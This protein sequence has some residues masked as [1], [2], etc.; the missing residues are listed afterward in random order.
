MRMVI[1]LEHKSLISFIVFEIINFIT[2]LM[3]RSI[4]S[5]AISDSLI[6]MSWSSSLTIMMN[7]SLQHLCPDVN[8][9]L[10][11]QHK[12]LIFQ[13]W[14]STLDNG[15]CLHRGAI[16]CLQGKGLSS[17]RISCIVGGEELYSC[18][19]FALGTFL[20]SD[21]VNLDFNNKFCSSTFW[22]HLYN[23]KESFWF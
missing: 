13:S 5:C 17:F 15:T 3:E 18:H 6:T 12:S 16:D 20:V 1:V 10:P 9:L 11:E 8:L 22:A 7:N 19:N 4:C 14:Y 2:K 23:F 21:L